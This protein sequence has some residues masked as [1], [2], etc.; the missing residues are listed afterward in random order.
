MSAWVSEN[1]AVVEGVLKQLGIK[2]DE[3]PVLVL[4]PN[5]LYKLKLL[6]NP[7]KVENTEG[8][9]VKVRSDANNTAYILFLQ[10]LLASKFIEV[11]AK[12]NDVLAVINMGKNMQTGYDYVVAHWNKTIDRYIS[13]VFKRI[14]KEKKFANLSFPQ[15]AEQDGMDMS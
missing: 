9:M 14:K 3:T 5:K 2:K 7:K 6:E 10:K 1:S 13:N 8:Y 15:P 11:K 12:K 4:K